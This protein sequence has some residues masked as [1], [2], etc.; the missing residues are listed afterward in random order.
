MP[1]PKAPPSL[2]PITPMP[3]DHQSAWVARI[4]V[5]QWGRIYAEALQAICERAFPA[6]VATPFCTGQEI[7]RAL[8][9]TPADLLLLSLSFP[10][11]DGIDLLQCVASEKLAR[12]VL[13]AT[14]RR[15]EHSLLALR[16]ARFDGLLDTLEESVEALV[17]ALHLV[18]AGNVYVSPAFRSQIIDRD[19]LGVLSQKLTAAEIR[20]FS[21]IGDGSGNGEAAARLGLRESTVQTHRRNIMHKLGIPSSAKLVREAIRLG[22]IR[23]TVEGRVIR[24][25]FETITA[26]PAS[27]SLTPWPT[28]AETPPLLRAAGAT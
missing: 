10:D 20:V 4:A 12:R 6:A 28:T 27:A 8:R 5:A 11:M 9:E 15:E 13:V 21:A 3:A 23:I 7:L 18:A 26:V 22:V 25:G 19:S 17:H 16:D 14:H 24:P 2:T 1:D